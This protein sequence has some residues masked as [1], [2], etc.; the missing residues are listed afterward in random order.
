MIIS[1]QDLILFYCWVIYYH[2]LHGHCSS[3]MPDSARARVYSTSLPNREAVI[4]SQIVLAST[5]FF[6][7]LANHSARELES[8]NTLP[9]LF[10]RKMLEAAGTQVL[11]IFVSKTCPLG[12][13]LT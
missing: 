12:Q 11:L 8:S 2:F 7:S 4:G 10:L 1:L 13:L 6:P 9:P 3:E 5:L